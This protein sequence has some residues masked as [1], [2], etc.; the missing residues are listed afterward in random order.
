M[1][2]LRVSRQAATPTRHLDRL[3]RKIR[4]FLV[5]KVVDKTDAIIELLPGQGATL[6][7]VVP[8]FEAS[9]AA[10]GCGVLGIVNRVAFQGRLTT[11]TGRLGDGEIPAQ[12]VARSP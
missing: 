10:G 3:V 2:A 11:V 1:R 12:T 7:D 9:P 5:E 6:G 8:I 4:Q